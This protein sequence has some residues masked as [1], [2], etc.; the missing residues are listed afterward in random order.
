MQALSAAQIR[1]AL[2][3]LQWD[4]TE[5]AELCEMSEVSMRKIARGLQQPHVKTETKIREK[6]EAAGIEFLP[7]D[8]VRLR[9][10]EVTVYEGRAQF[11]AFF[12]EVYA[13][14]CRQPDSV[15]HI[16]VSG[17]RE[18]DFKQ[19]TDPAI[20]ALHSA[21]MQANAARLNMRVILKEG[22]SDF[23]FAPYIHYRW[24]GRDWYD[25]APIYIFGPKL[26]LLNLQGVSP[27]VTVLTSPPHARAYR[28][29]FDRLWEGCKEPPKER[30]A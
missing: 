17:C 22:D 21:R 25:E 7:S 28:K 19:H 23:A 14:S 1:A 12:D 6:L 2:A 4:A 24:A 26:A 30:Y 18:A 8:G 15:F 13:E 10:K 9:A 3:L 20:D 29:Q 16:C 27:R 5:F 11:L